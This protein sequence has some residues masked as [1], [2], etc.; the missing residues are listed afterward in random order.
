MP[1]SIMSGS[2]G[3]LSRQLAELHRTEARPTAGRTGGSRTPRHVQWASRDDGRVSVGSAASPRPSM[4]ALDEMGLDPEAFETLRGALERHRSQSVN[5][6]N[7][8]NS[9]VRRSR[10]RRRSLSFIQPLTSNTIAIPPSRVHKNPTSETH[11]DTNDQ[12][13]KPF[14]I[15]PPLHLPVDDTDATLTTETSPTCTTGASSPFSDSS[16]LVERTRDV[17]GEVWVDPDEREGLPVRSLPLYRSLA[18]GV[19]NPDHSAPNHS[20]GAD[21]RMSRS[22]TLFGGFRGNSDGNVG[23]RLSTRHDTPVIDPGAEKE[24]ERLAAQHAAGVVRAHTRRGFSWLNSPPLRSGRRG[25]QENGKGEGRDNERSDTDLDEVEKPPTQGSRQGR[26]KRLR[27]SDLDLVTGAELDGMNVEQ[28]HSTS[29]IGRYGNKKTNKSTSS[30]LYSLVNRTAHSHGGFDGHDPESQ[31]GPSESTCVPNA[32]PLPGGGILSTLLALYGNDHEPE[33]VDEHS[34][35]GSV[36]GRSTPLPSSR[37]SSAAGTDDDRGEPELGELVRP[38][39]DRPKSNRGKCSEQTRRSPKTSSAS[40]LLHAF[41]LRTQSL[42]AS[43]S[44]TP[45][46][47]GTPVESAKVH[48]SETSISV[49]VPAS[50]ESS[51]VTSVPESGIPFNS[52]TLPSQTGAEGKGIKRGWKN[53][54]KDFPLPT[55]ISRTGT[56]STGT[57]TVSEWWRDISSSLPGDVRGWGWL[58]GDTTPKTSGGTSPMVGGVDGAGD[59]DYFVERW[60][61][62]ETRKRKE[63]EKEKLIEKQRKKQERKERKE[64]RKRKKTEAWITRHVAAILQRQEFILKLARAMMMFGGPSHRLV[65]QIQSTGRVLDIELSCMYLPDMMLVSFED[66]ATGT[67]NVK[68]IR[69]GSALDLE[70]LGEAYAL[71][72]NVIHDTMSVSQASAALDVLMRKKPLYNFIQLIL[73]GGMCSASICSVSFSGSFIDS[74]AS[75][76]L[77]ALL[78][79]VQLLSPRNEL[80][81]N[82]FEITIATLISFVSAALASTDKFC[83]SAV[84]SSS[85]VL[86]LPGFIVL[87]GS[88]ELSS[89]SLVAG[90]V[91]LCFAVM[92]SLFLGFGLAIGAEVYSKLIGKGII[93]PTDYTCV[94]SHDPAGPWWQQTP[95][96]WWAFL[97]VPMF[98]LFLSIRLMAPWWKRE[99]LL[100]IAISCVG[101]VT[102]HFVGLKFP[103]QND[104]SAAVG[105]FAV[106]FISNLY[107]R[108]FNGNAFIVMITGILFQVPSGLGN[109]G[110]L[111][112]VSDQTSGSSSSYISGFRTG[113]Q[114]ISVAIGLTVGLGISL[115]MVHPVQSRRRASGLFS[116]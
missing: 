23:R 36:N 6:R 116:L 27:H 63:K 9:V 7:Q 29:E 83:Y 30:W 67:S 96:L 60:A 35:E 14:R 82:V 89:R 104:I 85:V 106:G 18:L 76:P 40:S 94:A 61:E 34:D 98:S 11:S 93:G 78:V 49:P 109:G 48:L 47:A 74:L 22:N 2:S 38:W 111:N 54:L 43:T 115:V 81:G 37:A 88:L 52:V 25:S 100:L 53:V 97:T 84:A 71:Y 87:C 110:L 103:N 59:E 64:R 50:S 101:W 55:S 105:A 107:G 19:S 86:I 33:R 51:L 39:V 75:A 92:Y 95:S 13:L 1:I 58:S 69:Q 44:T 24:I 42:P 15:S 16:P 5:S 112:F 31:Q 20:G 72:W 57:T 56:T 62:Y 32:H 99:L 41:H 45:D 77:G 4:H 80:Y 90:A 91:R 21:G 8:E 108:F 70:K 17:P 65:A 26:R 28:L 10:H 3:G 68:F 73:I 102:N 79:A 46:I 113:L 114:L 66:S 12:S